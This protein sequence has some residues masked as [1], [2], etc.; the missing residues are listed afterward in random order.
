MRVFESSFLVR[1]PLAAV[2]QFHSDPAALIRITPGPFRIFVDSVDRPVRAGSHIRLSM[3][4]GPLRSRWHL[5]IADHQ[6]LVQF[7]DQLLPGEGP[8]KSWRHT[9]RFEPA[10]GGTRVIDRIEYELPFGWLGRLGGA[11][12]G[13]LAMNVLFSFRQTATKR[14]LE[15]AS[16]RT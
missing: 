7:I 8:F 1:A 14:L 12:G 16:T 3:G 5:I 4:F 10:E 6:P 9:H 11:L 13:S 2:W 15:D